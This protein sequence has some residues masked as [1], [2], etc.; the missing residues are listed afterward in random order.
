MEAWE[1]EQAAERH[2]DA[3]YR[4]ALQYTRQPADAEDVLQEVLLERYR[5]EQAFGSPEH[6][7]RWLL[8]VA[9]NKSRN[10]L[11]AGRRRRTVPLNEAA[12]LSA[13]EE[14]SFRALYDAVLALPRNQRLT[15]DLYYYEGY[16][17]EEI[18]A[19]LG[20]RP[21]TVRTW[22]RRARLKLKTLL[23]EAWSDDEL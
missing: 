8:R 2:G 1:L 20:V 21:A 23:K 22:L 15:V 16:S 11:R 14:P 4:T 12:A 3:I 17:T 19:L 7:R 9:V 18:G 6:E 13:P 10:L 5:T